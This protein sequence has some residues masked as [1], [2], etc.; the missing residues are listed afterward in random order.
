[1]KSIDALV[2]SYDDSNGLKRVINTLLKSSVKRIIVAFGF[3]L[4]SDG[5]FLDEITDDRVILLEEKERMGKVASINR[6][7]E[8]SESDILALMSSDLSFDPECLDLLL[9]Y[10]ED[11]NT[12]AVVPAVVPVKEK[13]IVRMAGKLLWYLRNSMLAYLDIVGGCVHGGEFLAM[14]REL[15]SKLPLVTND[16]EYLCLKIAETGSRVRFAQDIVIHNK[17][18]GNMEDYYTQRTRVIY[19]HRQMKSLGY[20]PPVLDF[21]VPSQLPL[22]LRIIFK[23]FARHPLSMMALPVLVILEACSIVMSRTYGKQSDPLKWKFAL[24]TK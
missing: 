16:E 11:E 12:G 4:S 18:P 6:A 22:F 14:R 23:T 15:V 3:T 9:K 19:G 1:M 5:M 2:M 13:G 20:S 21:M 17:T 7:L 24:S 8:H 10:F